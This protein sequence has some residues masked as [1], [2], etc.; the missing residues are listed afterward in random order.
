M[1][2]YPDQRYGAGCVNVVEVCAAPIFIGIPL[3]FTRDDD[4]TTTADY[5][6]SFVSGSNSFS[7]FVIHSGFSTSIVAIIAINIFFN[8]KCSN[9]LNTSIKQ[10]ESYW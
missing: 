5:I 4:N 7:I 9:N 1:C 6:P 10:P 3:R 2:P 8:V